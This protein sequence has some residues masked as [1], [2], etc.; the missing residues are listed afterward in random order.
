[1]IAKDND[2]GQLHDAA[3]TTV[4]MKEVL[5]S[6]WF[7]TDRLLL[8]QEDPLID[9]GSLLSTSTSSTS[10]PD[11]TRFENA[12]RLAL[13]LVRSFAEYY[14]F[15]GEQGE[16]H[17]DSQATNSICLDDLFVTLEGL[18]H[19][20]DYSRDSEDR[21]A[22]E[23][24]HND[25]A[26]NYCNSQNHQHDQN[27][28]KVP[29]M[30][31]TENTKHK[32]SEG[33]TTTAPY[34]SRSPVTDTK[35]PNF[36]MGFF[37]SFDDKGSNAY[38]D[39]FAKTTTES[40]TVVKSVRKPSPAPAIDTNKDA[41]GTELG[42]G[43]FSSQWNSPLP[44]EEDKTSLMNLTRDEHKRESD[45]TNYIPSDDADNIQ[46]FLTL[47]ATGRPLTNKVLIGVDIISPWCIEDS[48][49]DQNSGQTR[50]VSEAIQ[51][52]G[53]LLYSLFC[54]GNDPPSNYLPS[55]NL[56]PSSRVNAKG[57]REDVE[58]RQSKISRPSDTILFSLLLSNA[59]PISIC[60]LLSDMID[61]GPLGKAK[62]PFQS[63]EDVE[64]DLEEMKS[65]PQLH[66]HNSYSAGSFLSPPVFGREYCGRSTELARL[67]EIP[68]RI[69]WL[70]IS[71]SIRLQCV[72]DDSERG[73]NT[74]QRV[75]AVF[76]SG[77]GGSGKSHLV[78]K[79]GE[80]LSKQGWLVA[81]EKFQRGLEHNSQGVV[82]SLLDKLVK[83]LV[84]MKNGSVHKDVEYSN[85]VAKMLESSFDSSSLS[86]LM[87]YLP[88]I[89]NL[90]EGTNS[91]KRTS[92]VE[93]NLTHWQLVFLVTR[94]VQSLLKMDRPIM[95][96][97]DDFQ[98][99]DALTIDLVLGDI[100]SSVFDQKKSDRFMF[101]GMYRDDEVF[102]EHP[103][104]MKLSNL[105]Q[106]GNANVTE[107]PLDGFSKRDITDMIATE[108]KLP[109]RIVSEL[110]D[111]VH[112]KTSGHILYAVKLLNS[113]VRDS[114]IYFDLKLCR[115]DWRWDKVCTLKTA[116]GVADFIVSTFSKLEPEVL[117][118]LRI[119]SCLG[120][121]C[122]FDVI[123]LLDSSSVESFQGISSALQHLADVGII[124]I[125]G[126]LVEFT[127]DLIQQHVYEGFELEQRK[128]LHLQIGL[129]LGW[130]TSAVNLLEG[131][132]KKKM[133]LSHSTNDISVISE[134]SL[135]CIAT[136]Q[137]NHAGPE[138]VEASQR[139]VF[140]AWNL[141][142][143][144][145][146]S[147][148]FN[149]GCALHYYDQGISFIGKDFWIIEFLVDGT[150]LCLDLYQG[151]AEAASSIRHDSKVAY[152]TNSIIRNAPFEST[153][154]AWVIFMSCLESSGKHFEIIEKGFNLMRIMKIEIPTT[155]PSI[156][157]IME[158][159]TK[160][161]IFASRYCINQ[162]VGISQKRPDKQNRNL[163]RLFDA[164]TVAA[165]SVSSPYLPLLTF[166][167]VYYCLQNE[168]FETESA[169][170]F[171]GF[172]YF[173]IALKQDYEKGKY[174]AKIAL[175]I[176]KQTRPSSAT[177]RARWM[178]YG[179]IML[180]FIPLKEA[181]R[182]LF[183]T[184]QL[185]MKLGDFKTAV[186]A[187]TLSTNIALLE[188]ENL[189]LL[190]RDRF[191]E[192][193]K[194]VKYNIECAKLAVLDVVLVD[195]LRGEN[196]NPF[197]IF[198]GK[199]SSVDDLMM[200]AV[201]N[202]NINLISNIYFRRLFLAFWEGN[203]DVAESHLRDISSLPSAKQPKLTTIYLTFFSGILAFHR[204][205]QSQAEKDLRLGMDAICKF[206]FWLKFSPSN[207][208]NKLFLLNAEQTSLLDIEEA[209]K[210][211]E[212]SIKS[213]RDNGRVHE[214]GLANELMGKTF[215][216]VA[217]KSAYAI[218]CLK[219]ARICYLQWGAMKKAASIREK[220][221]LDM[222]DT[223]SHR[224]PLK[225]ARDS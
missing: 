16:D 212:A 178:L 103:L 153:L 174:W 21:K 9:E 163:L 31:A 49:E 186:S 137:I 183:A 77:R 188:G 192:M 90:I 159:M 141:S 138:F 196:T 177:V 194:V 5:Q 198:D 1:M 84:R 74:A 42:L 100:L 68:S 15:G 57:N 221:G 152:Y 101:V 48:E 40:P 199:F 213:A 47:Q 55:S 130:K 34:K 132:F 67:L 185:G 64:R 27:C 131:D 75:E 197:A 79:C 72:D 97:L 76:V 209:K 17:H 203:Y 117:H 180:W 224:N 210:H 46:T 110:G 202:K 93:T 129:F 190:T 78:Q 166:E 7:S 85:N 149:F 66:L 62:N 145:E 168:F 136:D 112:K 53:C 143:G 169:V 146:L 50:D 60:H 142:V 207:F 127:H 82:C 13:L 99:A 164:I 201:T 98:W 52:L 65:N 204:Y 10:S 25:S 80:F 36:E 102:G 39:F 158:S 71:T 147:A 87:W 175:E 43:Y 181:A 96:I 114:T 26:D 95:L 24:T 4:P 162:G 211:Y 187:L 182:K 206:E 6:A 121:Q 217:N 8:Q 154:P 179:H 156:M 220:Y 225:H 216:T 23:A 115:F 22:I 161:T 176:L 45:D 20:G 19:E 51:H 44:V 29:A 123:E 184:N 219:K 191:S 108:L 94:F 172:G 118:S 189:L 58:G 28:K 109:R 3:T 155:P 106:S 218:E 223:N 208:E 35:K 173:H 91:V 167:M 111:V 165:Y 37:S 56:P 88:S 195:E 160:T 122:D 18:H 54:H 86:S 222:N 151:A 63:I 89:Q 2:R 150:Q 120:F 69:E 81:G 73:V 105:R 215:S 171:A 104:S 92:F 11:E 41:N 140:A 148:S 157:D 134:R 32:M 200:D 113:M 214:Q 70:R 193:K 126:G 139:N 133:Y 116:D 124:E 83:Q 128:K 33:A 144:K 205:R 30:L 135:L 170:A 38:Q 107:I 14:G 12:V 59:L 61:I 119:L 125:A